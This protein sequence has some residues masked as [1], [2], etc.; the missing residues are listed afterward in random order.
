MPESPKQP[1]E[2]PAEK[3]KGV[4]ETKSRDILKENY[5]FVIALV[6]II[7][8]MIFFGVVLIGFKDFVLLEKMTALL[9]ALVA[10]VLGYYFGQRPVRELTNQ[11]SQAQLER[12]QSRDQFETSR[13]DLFKIHRQYEDSKKLIEEYDKMFKS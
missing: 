9:S 6:V 5:S 7:P 10:A 4:P 3:P 11:I 8:F 13:K 1:P 12:D 2:Q